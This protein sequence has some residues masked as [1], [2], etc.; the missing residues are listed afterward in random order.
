MSPSRPP[1]ET[2]T[3]A[4]A[5]PAFSSTGLVPI[6]PSVFITSDLCT[7]GKPDPQ[8]YLKGAEASN[9]PPQDCLVVEDAPAGVRAGKAAGAK[10]L[11]LKTTHDGLKQWQNGADFLVQDLSH[12][13]AQWVKKESGDGEELRIT[14]KT[15]TKPENL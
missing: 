15:E 14:I 7:A 10:V 8:P 5:F 6:P 3:K 13:S 4:Y 1:I 12:V 9:H 11:G 2:A